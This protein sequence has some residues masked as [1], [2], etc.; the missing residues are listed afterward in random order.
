[1]GEEMAPIEFG[2]FLATL[3]GK[4]I[5]FANNVKIKDVEK[6]KFSEQTNV[7]ELDDGKMKGE[8][9]PS[10]FSLT[11]TIEPSRGLNKLLG[12]YRLNRGSSR[13]LNQKWGRYRYYLAKISKKSR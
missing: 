5:L 9:Y 11:A 3:Q 1:M 8:L 12:R 4:P 13:T 10:N 2:K 7:P 6:D